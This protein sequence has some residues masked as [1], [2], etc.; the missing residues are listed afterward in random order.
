MH[1]RAGVH[2]LWQGI[3][4]RRTR[5]VGCVASLVLPSLPRKG[6]R[7]VPVW[8]HEDLLPGRPGGLP[9][10]ASRRQVPGSH[11]HDPEDGP[12]LA[13]EGEI[14]QVEGGYLNSA[15]VLPRTPGPQVS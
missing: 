6:S 15:E 13:T 14:P 7:Q 3:L 8:P 4:P 1:P 2:E 12:R 10:E 11:H 9:R 5:V